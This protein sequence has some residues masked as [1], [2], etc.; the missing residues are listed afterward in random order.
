M[1]PNLVAIL[2]ATRIPIKPSDGYL[3]YKY[4]GVIPGNG[5]EQAYAPALQKALGRAFPMQ[6]WKRSLM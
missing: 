5:L 1:P 4:P 6:H 2:G 3:D